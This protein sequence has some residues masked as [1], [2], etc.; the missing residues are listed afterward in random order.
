M[1]KQTQS[2]QGGNNTN[3]YNPQKTQSVTHNAT[4]NDQ[5][6]ASLNESTFA[7]EFDMST[8]TNTTSALDSAL[9]IALFVV[10]PLAI[11]FY[12]LQPKIKK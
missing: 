1:L 10:L 9:Y 2:E 3:T 7:R 5:R 4:K 8:Q 11:L 12:R 6:A